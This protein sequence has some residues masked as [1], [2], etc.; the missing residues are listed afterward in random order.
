MDN[1]I[2]EV[3]R[4]EYVG[5]VDQ[6]KPDFRL[7][8]NFNEVNGYKVMKISGKKSRLHLCSR[9]IDEETGEEHYYIFNMPDDDERRS[10]TPKRKIVLE[11]KEEVQA[12]FDILSKL[13]KGDKK[14]D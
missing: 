11:S 8:E 5:F 3:N 12:F 14:N 7:V 6:I 4:D 10:A 2:Y 9:F 13:Q 1:S